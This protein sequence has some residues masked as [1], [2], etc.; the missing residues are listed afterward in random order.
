MDDVI[1]YAADQRLELW[2]KESGWP[3]GFTLFINHELRREAGDIRTHVFP[4]QRSAGVNAVVVRFTGP[5]A[6]HSSIVD[7][8]GRKRMVQARPDHVYLIRA[9]K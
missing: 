8:Q 4:I 7:A 1:D 5:E 9:S 2:I 3:L 6:G